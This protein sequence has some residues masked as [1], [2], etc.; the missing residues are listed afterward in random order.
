MKT[1]EQVKEALR[2]LNKALLNDEGYCYLD[3]GDPAGG[4]ELHDDAAIKVAIRVL[5]EILSLEETP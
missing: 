1:E 5:R 2:E 3:M 4:I